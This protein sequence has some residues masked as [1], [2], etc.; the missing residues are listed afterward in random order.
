MKTETK[1]ISNTPFTKIQGGVYA[2]INGK[3]C[4]LKTKFS[5][6]SIEMDKKRLGIILK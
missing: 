5:L 4:H 1:T 6:N 3:Q 2:T